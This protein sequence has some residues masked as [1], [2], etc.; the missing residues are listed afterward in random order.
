MEKLIWTVKY[1]GGKEVNYDIIGNVYNAFKHGAVVTKV[2]KVTKKQVGTIK[3]EMENK[4]G[5]MVIKEYPK[6]EFKEEV[7]NWKVPEIWYGSKAVFDG[8]VG[9]I[10]SITGSKFTG[11]V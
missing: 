5:I 10:K 9:A 4:D 3:G 6:Y 2:V 7:I 1:L 8:D 11:I